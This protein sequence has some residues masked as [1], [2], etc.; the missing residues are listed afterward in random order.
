MQEMQYTIK[1]ADN[2]TKPRKGSESIR[3]TIKRNIQMP[4]M[5]S[6][7]TKIYRGRMKQLRHF[8]T[9]DNSKNLRTRYKP[10]PSCPQCHSTK[11]QMALDYPNSRNMAC[12]K[13]GHISE[14]TKFILYE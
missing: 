11:V 9:K 1:E 4:K 14:E 8:I 2:T 5:L 7:R 6:K 3:N 10:N 13:C 12:K